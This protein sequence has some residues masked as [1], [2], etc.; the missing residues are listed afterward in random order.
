MSLP[1]LSTGTGTDDRS[2]S[3]VVLVTPHALDGDRLARLVEEFEVVVVTHDVH[4]AATVLGRLERLERL[5][6]LEA[7]LPDSGAPCAARVA[8]ALRSVGPPLTGREREILTLLLDHTGEVLTYREIFERVW[9]T[10][11]LGDPALVH[12]ALKRVRRKLREAGADVVIDAV[13]GVGFR[14]GRPA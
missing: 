11:Y 3:M 13:R 9:R 12:S 5:E 10:H 4:L 2:P 14:A 8:P 6:P 1:E 7:P